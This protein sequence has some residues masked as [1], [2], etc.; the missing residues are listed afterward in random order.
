MCSDHNVFVQHVSEHPRNNY[1]CSLLH[2]CENDQHFCK[3][4]LV[5]SQRELIALQGYK[6]CQLGHPV[7]SLCFCLLPHIWKVQHTK[8]DFHIV[9]LT[10]GCKQAPNCA[11]FQDIWKVFWIINH[12]RLLEWHPGKGWK[13]AVTGIIRGLYYHLIT[14]V[15]ML[16][17]RR[18]QA[19]T[20]C[21]NYILTS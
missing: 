7:K 12:A 20:S 14:A 5:T 4:P 10:G 17:A 13:S 3:S 11:K 1:L 2:G 21:N 18:H 16:N 15:L 19:A 6:R 8:S 9:V